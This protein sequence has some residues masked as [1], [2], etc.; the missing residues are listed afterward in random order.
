MLSVSLDDEEK[1]ASDT[2]SPYLTEYWLIFFMSVMVKDG[3]VQ[4]KCSYTERYWAKSQGSIF[5]TD[6]RR[7]ELPKKIKGDTGM[8]P[9][10][11]GK[12]KLFESQ[13]NFSA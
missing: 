4:F 2:F 12:V 10:I 8:E 13:D 11:V 1:N 6:M 5:M 9:I 3:G 7:L